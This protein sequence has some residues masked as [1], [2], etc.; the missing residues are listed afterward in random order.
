VGPAEIERIEAALGNRERTAFLRDYAEDGAAWRARVA[1]A[2]QEMDAALARLE[3][4]LG[5]APWLS[6]RA[7]GLADAAWVVNLHRLFQA[8]Y[9]LATLPRLAGWYARSQARPSFRRA[10]HEWRPDGST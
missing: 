5:T 10:V 2:E 4:A 8:K 7:F 6:G 9:P 1:R 3:R